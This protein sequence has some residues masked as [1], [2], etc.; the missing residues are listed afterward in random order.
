MGLWAKHSAFHG[1]DMELA[2]GSAQC[3]TTCALHRRRL[4]G[5]LVPGT[6]DLSCN[7]ALPRCRAGTPSPLWGALLQRIPLLT[8]ILAVTLHSSVTHHLTRIHTPL[9]YLPL[10]SIFW[11]A[12]L[13]NSSFFAAVHC[14]DYICGCAA[15]PCRSAF[16][17]AYLLAFLAHHAS[18][19][20][21]LLPPGQ[22]TILH[23]RAGALLASTRFTVCT[24]LQSFSCRRHLVPLK[25][26]LLRLASISGT[27]AGLASYSLSVLTTTL[28]WTILRLNDLPSSASSKAD[29]GA[30]LEGDAHLPP[31][32][33]FSVAHNKH[34]PAS[35]EEDIPHT[36]NSACI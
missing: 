2:P 8:P 13:T 29:T 19:A 25:W 11:L 7:A 34:L 27:A 31:S 4:L 6:R 35:L 18:S 28:S 24:A 15:L 23:T 16:A 30:R 12:Y 20:H 33:T 1:W 21:S 36:Y 22:S 10:H 14:N 17:S 3:C 26:C 32:C 5:P 9:H